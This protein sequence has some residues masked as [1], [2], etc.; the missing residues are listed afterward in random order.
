MPLTPYLLSAVSMRKAVKVFIVMIVLLVASVFTMFFCLVS[1]RTGLWDYDQ[2]VSPWRDSF[3]SFFPKQIPFDAAQVRYFHRP[4]VM[5][6][7][8]SIQLRMVLPEVSVRQ[9]HAKAL[10][11]AL[12]RSNGRRPSDESEGLMPRTVRAAKGSARDP[13]ADYQVFVLN[14]T[15]SEENWNH[16]VE[17]GVAVSLKYNEVVYWLEN[18]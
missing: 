14:T 16:G 8:E 15:R 9:I 1:D 3:T 10:R 13:V 12:S 2:A 7:G 6:G 11:D 17:S 5:Q 4:A 18:W